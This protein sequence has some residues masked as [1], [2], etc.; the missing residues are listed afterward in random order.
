MLRFLYGHAL[1]RH[2]RLAQSMFRDRALQFFHRHGWAVTVDEK[3]EERD[4]YDALNPLYVIW[5]RPDGLHGGSARFLP[6]T[7]QTMVNDHFLHLTQGVAIRS[8]FIWECTRFC[9]APGDGRNRIASALMLGGS[10]LMRAFGLEHFVGVFDAPMIRAY[11]HMGA[12]PDVLGTARGISVGLWSYDP[13]LRAGLAARAGVSLAMAE[14]WRD[15]GLHG[16]GAADEPV[17]RS[18]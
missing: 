6:T 18:A 12:V 11:R 10:E 17:R 13:D 3:G 9:L 8:P 14:T 16:A 15:H 5:E 1:D 7:G 2:P 4:Q